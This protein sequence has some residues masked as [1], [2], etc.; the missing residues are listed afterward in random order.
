MLAIID[1]E[2]ADELEHHNHANHFLGAHG[3]ATGSGAV[4]GHDAHAH[5]HLAHPRMLSAVLPGGFVYLHGFV[6]AAV[7]QAHSLTT[8][9]SVEG[10]VRVID[11]DKSSLCC[12]SMDEHER[13]VSLAY[14]GRPDVEPQNLLRVVGLHVAYLN[15]VSRKHDS[16]ALVD[17]IA[18]LREPWAQ[19]IYHDHFRTL[20]IAL[21]HSLH[22]EE[23]GCVSSRCVP[24][25]RVPLHRLQCA[26]PLW[27]AGD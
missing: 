6:G 7:T 26:A 25:C 1:P 16:G 12:L 23:V 9:V 22:D 4:E 27:L 18:F 13:V 20:C 10:D 8:D 19:A 5:D 2:T 24:P 15:G 11:D 21:Q 17:L 3:D 14:L